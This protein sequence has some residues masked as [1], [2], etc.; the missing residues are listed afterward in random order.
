MKTKQF[1][2]KQLILTTPTISKQII[3]ANMAT[4]YHQIIL[5]NKKLE[6]L[7]HTKRLEH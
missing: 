6:L 3:M 5:H 1:T 2:D 7:R 4:N